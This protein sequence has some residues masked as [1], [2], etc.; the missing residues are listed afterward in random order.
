MADEIKEFGWG[1]TVT[2]RLP[3]IPTYNPQVVR[4]VI[5]AED[6]YKEAKDNG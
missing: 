2:I 5:S 6:L 4:L 1:D 3:D